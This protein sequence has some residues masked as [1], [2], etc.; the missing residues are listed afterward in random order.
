[1]EKLLRCSK[2]K[3]L[4]PCSQYNKYSTISRGYSYACKE[5]T[6]LYTHRQDVRERRLKYHREYDKINWEKKKEYRKQH[7]HEASERSKKH[8]FKVSYGLELEDYDRMLLD[9]N[10][11]CAICGTSS[12][13]GKYNRF[14]IDHCHRTGKVRGLL[15]NTCNF[16]LGAFKDSVE[17]L[18]NAIKYLI[19]D[20]I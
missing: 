11:K 14:Y 18:Q 4:K 15:C 1:M 10:G 16:A 19:N 6:K 12:P 9:Q 3:E 20:K 5:C 7:T 17:N 13:S 8:H 2:C